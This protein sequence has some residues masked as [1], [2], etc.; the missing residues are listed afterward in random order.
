MHRPDDAGTAER[1]TT[2]EPAGHAVETHALDPQAAHATLDPLRH[3]PAGP[4]P[5]GNPS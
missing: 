3:S 2:V 1:S 4:A 5:G